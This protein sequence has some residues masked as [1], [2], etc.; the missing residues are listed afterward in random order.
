M[1]PHVQSELIS[2]R[3]HAVTAPSEDSGWIW[4]EV[5]TSVALTGMCVAALFSGI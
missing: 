3:I 5:L 2:R 4:A 1:S